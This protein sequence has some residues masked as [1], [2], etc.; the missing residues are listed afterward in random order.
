MEKET[1]SVKDKLQEAQGEEEKTKSLGLEQKKLL[2]KRFQL[3]SKR[4]TQ[5]AMAQTYHD[6]S[7]KA[8]A[9]L[10]QLQ[11]EGEDLGRKDDTL[12]EL[13]AAAEEGM[14]MVATD[15]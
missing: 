11:T 8:Q 1:A 14:Q 6:D 12:V 10:H 7:A 2:N 9:E 13:I 5:E 15:W 3:I 4:G